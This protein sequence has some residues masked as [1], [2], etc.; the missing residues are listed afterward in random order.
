MIIYAPHKP[1][2][3]WKLASVRKTMAAQGAPVIRVVQQGENYIALEGSHRIAVAFGQESLEPTIIL[4]VV[5]SDDVVEHD[6]NEFDS[7][8]RA[9]EI[10]DWL[11]SPDKGEE[12][13]GVDWLIPYSWR[14]E[15]VSFA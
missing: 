9:Q 12:Y 6:F 3:T 5:R 10:V 8:C 13:E 1:A 11:Q 2:N 4:Q 14:E 15:S 7:P